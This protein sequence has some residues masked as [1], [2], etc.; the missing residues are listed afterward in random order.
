MSGSEENIH[1]ISDQDS[2]DEKPQIESIIKEKSKIFRNESYVIKILLSDHHRDMRSK[3]FSNV[4]TV[5]DSIYQAI[6]REIRNCLNPYRIFIGKD[7]NTSKEVQ[8]LY[9]LLKLYYK[10]KNFNNT[11]FINYFKDLENAHKKINTKFINMLPTN[12]IETLNDL[13]R[14]VT[15]IRA[16]R[17]YINTTIRDRIQINFEQKKKY[18]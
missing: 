12:E 15:I 8:E 9:Q 17:H 2:N 14:K 11:F 7:T 5:H 1:Y 13:Q 18:I 16:L 3:F 6:K 10:E 4:R